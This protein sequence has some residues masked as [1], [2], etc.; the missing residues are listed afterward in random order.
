VAVLSQWRKDRQIPTGPESEAVT[1]CP[2]RGHEMARV[3]SP[4][5][6]LYQC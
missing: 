6:A 5:H 2:L 1:A 3:L 4:H